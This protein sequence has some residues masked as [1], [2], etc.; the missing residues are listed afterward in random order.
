M[1]KGGSSYSTRETPWNAIG[2]PEKGSLRRFRLRHPEIATRK[3][4]GLEINRDH[5]LFPNV[6]ETLY[7]NPKELYLTFKYPPSHIW[8]CDKSGVQAGENGG[9]TVLPKWGTRSMHSIEPDQ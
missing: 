2:V 8:N 1:F 4:Q 6:A 5:A 7:T 9:A 3:S